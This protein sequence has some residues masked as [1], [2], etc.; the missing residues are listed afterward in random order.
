MLTFSDKEDEDVAEEA[1]ALAALAV[2]ARDAKEAIAGNDD[3]DNIGDFDVDD[4]NAKRSG[5][6]EAPGPPIRESAIAVARSMIVLV[7]LL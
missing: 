7:L 5:E 3:F 4:A 1:E 2:T 6:E